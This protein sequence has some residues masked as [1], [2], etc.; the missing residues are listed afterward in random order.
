[1]VEGIY[2]AANNGAKVVNASINGEGYCISE[3]N[4]I[5]YANSLGVLF[6]AA[7]GNG[8]DDGIGDNNDVSP[9]FPASYDLPNIISVAA[10]DQDDRKVPFSN[11]GPNTVHVAAPGEYIFSTVPNW[12]SLYYG[13][14]YLETFAGTSM[15]AP[16]VAGLA[17]LLF[18]YYDGI[19]NTAFSHLQVRNTV[20]RYVDVLPTL[21]GWIYSRGRINAFRALSSLLAPT[22]LTARTSVSST[23]VSLFWED[24]A[25][26]EDGYKVERS[27][28]GVAF[29]EIAALPA[30]TTSYEDSSVTAG[31]SYTYRVRAYNDIAA[32]FSSNAESVTVPKKRHGGGGGGCSIGG[33]QNTA[34]ALA[35]L[36]VMLIP[37]LFIAVMRR[38]R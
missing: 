17:G 32:S 8:G 11:Y 1:V 33:G 10:T 9:H 26:G 28:D 19:E 38:R 24:K 27:A 29:A 18:S 12:W 3:F 36:T 30:G 15:A 13:Y 34:T 6:V 23:K 37:L 5:N 22:N 21:D 7:A 4:A 31:S 20:L 35:D 16:H 25:T 2:Y 14:G